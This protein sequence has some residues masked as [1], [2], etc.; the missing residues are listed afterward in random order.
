MIITIS[1]PS[2]TGK[3]SMIE[4]LKAHQAYIESLAG[5]PAVFGRES[6]REVVGSQYGAKSLQEIFQDQEEALKLQFKVAEYNKEL[7]TGIAGDKGRLHIF[8]RGPLD[9]LIYTLLCFSSCPSSLMAKHAS[10][11]S[12]RCAL[13][14]CLAGSVDLT[15]LTRPDD[16]VLA[17]E[18]DGFRPDLFA[19]LRC[20][21][22]EL[23]S[24]VFR[25]LNAVCLPSDHNDRLVCFF[26][27]LARLAKKK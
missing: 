2:S 17:P 7:Y 24:L 15:L 13:N 8:D 22:T 16:M 23:F 25:G 4:N 20:A 14:Q 9:N 5:M 18:D 12:R 10:E 26:T 1:G 11:F 19:A 27:E 3:T 6:V 21:E